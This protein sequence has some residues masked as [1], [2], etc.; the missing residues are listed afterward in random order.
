MPIDVASGGFLPGARSGAL[1]NIPLTPCCLP[2][3]QTI[4][5]GHAYPHEVTG[6]GQAYKNEAFDKEEN[7]LTAAKVQMQIDMALGKLKEELT[8]PSDKSE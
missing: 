3:H 2:P 4:P 1:I 8:H 5:G 6:K 7:G